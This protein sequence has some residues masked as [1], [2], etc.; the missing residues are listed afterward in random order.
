[1]RQN[2]E[3]MER[4][5]WLAIAHVWDTIVTDTRGYLSRPAAEAGQLA[6]W[7]GRLAYADPAWTPA[8][9]PSPAVRGFP[10]LNLR[11]EFFLLPY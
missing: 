5:T 7:T 6:L 2:A 11:T 1:M 8:R 9:G 4:R 10:R 3:D